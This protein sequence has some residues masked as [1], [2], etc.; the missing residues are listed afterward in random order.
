MNPELKS[1][2]QWNGQHLGKCKRTNIVEK[3][4]VGKLFLYKLLV[5]ENQQSVTWECMVRLDRYSL[6]ALADECA[7]LFGF[8]KAGTCTLAIGKTYYTCSALNFSQ[9]KKM[10][11]SA[12][13]QP[14]FRRRVQDFL[15]WRWIFGVPVDYRKDLFYHGTNICAQ[16]TNPQPVVDGF[17]EEDWFVDS[18]ADSKQRL[19]RGRKA[20]ILSWTIQARMKEINS[21]AIIHLQHIKNRLSLH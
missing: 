17:L 7:D 18:L 12:D 2:T 3:K 5:V 14:L 1:P 21:S 6:L 4:K 9:L 20:E 13:T 8:A 11:I 19:L 10:Q 16:F 15:V